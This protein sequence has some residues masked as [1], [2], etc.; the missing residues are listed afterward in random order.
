M[1]R[2]TLIEIH[3]RTSQK[4]GVSSADSAILRIGLCRNSGTQL[5]LIESKGVEEAG[6]AR[7]TVIPSGET[8]MQRELIDKTYL[9]K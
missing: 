5:I 4:S 7:L 9:K 3:T 8:R 1:H 2:P 6:T